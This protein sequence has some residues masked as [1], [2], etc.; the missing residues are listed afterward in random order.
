MVAGQYQVKPDL[1]FVPGTEISGVVEHAPRDSGFKSGDRVSALLDNGGL[2][3]GGYAET[4]DAHA[5]TVRRIDD[6][7]PFDDAAAFTLIYQTAS[8]GLHRRANLLRGE[9]PLCTPAAAG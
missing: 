7:M 9:P 4:A 8:F 5:D 3:R 6:S 2:T 1:P